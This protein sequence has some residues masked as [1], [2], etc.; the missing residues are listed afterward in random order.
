MLVKGVH[1]IDFIANKQ[2]ETKLFFIVF[3]V[4]GIIGLLIPFTYPLF[5]KLIPFALILSFVAL[6]IFHS[7]KFNKK[8][9][10]VFSGIFISGY[11]IEV[12]GVNTGFIFGNY[13]YGKSL[14][15]SIFNTPL[16]IG[17]NWL[18]LIYTSSSV[19]EKFKL[20]I[21]SKVVLASLIMVL[22]DIVMEQVAP[23][24]DM[25]NW[26]NNIVPFQNYMAWFVVS[27]FFHSIIKGLK[28][29]TQNKLAFLV[30]ICQILFFMSL[31]IF[32][33]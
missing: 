8:S 29:N 23:K 33:I 31:Y 7:N 19:L 15:F 25:W 24:I 10:F 27:V 16:I 20:N 30:I 1:F 13:Q 26:Y 32:I 11:F 9:I 14:G 18:F 28:I 21:I 12:I 2:K 5:L 3:Y 22:Y 17:L 4:V 6:V